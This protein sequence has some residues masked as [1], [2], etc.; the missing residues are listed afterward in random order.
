MR[1]LETSFLPGRSFASPQDFNDQLRLWLPIARC[2]IAA[3]DCANCAHGSRALTL[4]VFD[5]AELIDHRVGDPALP[6]VADDFC[7]RFRSAAWPFGVG[8]SRVPS[9]LASPPAWISSGQAKL[10]MGSPA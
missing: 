10:A 5:P 6:Q 8:W 9:S 7:R 2:E 4:D 3:E 1:Y